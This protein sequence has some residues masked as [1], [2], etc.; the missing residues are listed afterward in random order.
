MKLYF[1]N[2]KTVVSCQKSHLKVGTQPTNGIQDPWQ[3][4]CFFLISLNINSMIHKIK[5]IKV[6]AENN[7]FEV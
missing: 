3:L 7:N 2:V 5:K 4:T 1:K 6:N